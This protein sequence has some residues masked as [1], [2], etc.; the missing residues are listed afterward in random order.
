[1]PSFFDPRLLMQFLAVYP[2]NSKITLASTDEIRM[3]VAHPSPVRR[4]LFSLSLHVLEVQQV[5]ETA[6]TRAPGSGQSPLLLVRQS[7][8]RFRACVGAGPTFRVRRVHGARAAGSA[9]DLGEGWVRGDE[10]DGLGAGGKGHLTRGQGSGKETVGSI[11]AH[12]RR[13][14]G[15][16]IR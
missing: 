8:G 12:G 1:M 2:T 6:R 7:G 3:T 16:G 9:E 13:G 11:D 14:R 15:W 5:L 4:W 10:I